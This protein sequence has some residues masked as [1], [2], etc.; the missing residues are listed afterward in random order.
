MTTLPSPNSD[1]KHLS[2]QLLQQIKNEIT[3]QGAI[4]FEQYMSLA[5][6]APQFGYYRNGLEKLGESGDFVTAPEISPLFSR[7]IANQCAQVLSD[8][9][10]GDILEFGAGRG[11]MAADILLHLETSNVLPNRYF[12]LELS[13]Q[14]QVIQKETI[15]KKAPHLLDRVCWLTQLPSEPIVGVVLAN[16]VLDAMPVTLFHWDQGFKVAG[17][18][19]QNDVLTP[20]L[21]SKETTSL[22]F[23]LRDV[24]FGAGY[25]SEINLHLPGWFAALSDS[26]ARGL[27]LIIDYGF[28][29]SE[30]YHPD[31]D[32]GTLMCHYQHIAHPDPFWYPGLQDI[33]AHVD[34]T[35]VA[36]ASDAA[37]FSVN[38]YTNQA[39][40][41]M[42]AG[43]LTLLDTQSSV[44]NRFAENQAVLRLTMPS[45]MGELFKVM[46]LTKGYDETLLGFQSMSQLAR[47]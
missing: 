46:A 26:M 33:T 4:S 22:A 3:Q 38:G 19:V 27:V 29:R 37:G 11:V 41:L 32:Q 12:I 42:N 23:Q 40:F 6:Y 44:E 20:C 10:G 25:T 43:L 34:F 21:L 18:T 28:P 35:A 31:R 5:L 16:E 30:Y 36:E 1:A 7:C 9:K 14:L 47:L 24:T 2:N 45:E 15:K 13:A 39:S 17:V 8:L